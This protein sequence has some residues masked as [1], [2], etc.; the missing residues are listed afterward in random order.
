MSIAIYGSTWWYKAVHVLPK[1]LAII[2]D[3]INA[4]NSPNHR[5]MFFIM[6]AN[7]FP[8]ADV[9]LFRR[10]YTGSFLVMSNPFGIA[11]ACFMSRGT[12]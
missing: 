10:L 7:G 5:A 4:F 2:P 6:D 3:I 8:E 1:G 11:A 9:A 12:P